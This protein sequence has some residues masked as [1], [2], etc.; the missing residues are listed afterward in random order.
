MELLALNEKIKTFLEED[1]FSSNFYYLNN[2]PAE[3]SQATLNI[4]SDV[5]LSGLPF[6]N[7]VFE[8]LGFKLSQDDLSKFEG[9][10]FK[11]GTKIGLKT[12]IPFNILLTGERLALNLLAHST[13]ISTFTKKFVDLAQAKNIKIL[14]TRKTTPGL[15]F[16]E[17]YAVRVGGAQNH[18]FSQMDAFMIK[19]NHKSYFGNIEKSLKFFNNL[20]SHY[21]PTILEIH[22]LDELMT[23]QEMNVQ[24]FLLD[25]FTTE[26]LIQAIKV[27]RPNNHYEV[28]GGINLENLNQY[29]IEG[30]D[31]ISVGA[32][33]HS[34]PSVDLSLKYNK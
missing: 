6:F 23:A 14:D 7:Q 13:K 34:A 11:A 2:L 1:D 12:K 18:R 15:R 27:K 32:L 25:N 16:L 17:K 10:F 24:N 22:N 26:M 9:Q 21:V 30:I 5:V 8:V 33:T 31:A 20:G 19:D 4:K 28:S 29:L 3:L